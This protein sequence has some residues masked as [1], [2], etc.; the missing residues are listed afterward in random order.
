MLNP[1]SLFGVL[2]ISAFPLANSKSEVLQISPFSTIFQKSGVLQIWT[3]A[4][5]KFILEYFKF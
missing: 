4:K 3:F 5:E 2:Q 1:D